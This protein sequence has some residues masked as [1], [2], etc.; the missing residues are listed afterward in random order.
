MEE[1]NIIIKIKKHALNRVEKC[2][3]GLSIRGQQIVINHVIE[4]FA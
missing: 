1:M 4:T 3:S 2:L